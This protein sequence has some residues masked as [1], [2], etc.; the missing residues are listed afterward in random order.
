M[1]TTASGIPQQPFVKHEENNSVENKEVLVVINAFHSELSEHLN[2]PSDDLNIQ[3]KKINALK[4]NAENFCKNHKDQGH[5]VDLDVLL[6]T[7]EIALQKCRAQLGNALLKL[8]SDL[9]ETWARCKKI[10]R[11]GRSDFREIETGVDEL[12]EE[13]LK[14]KRKEK[15][16]YELNLLRVI[17]ER[18]IGSTEPYPFGPPIK[19]SLEQ[20]RAKLEKELNELG[21]STSFQGDLNAKAQNKSGENAEWGKHIR[22]KNKNVRHIKKMQIIRFG[23]E[24]V[25][26]IDKSK[27]IGSGGNGAV[28]NAYPVQ[29]DG[30]IDLHVPL[31]FKFSTEEVEASIEHAKRD[32]YTV[33]EVR[34][35][36]QQFETR[37]ARILTYD[38]AKKPVYQTV[39][40]MPKVPGKSLL[41]LIKT[42]KIQKLSR[43]EKIRLAINIIDTY[44]QSHKDGIFS[45]DTKLE[46]IMVNPET[47]EVTQIDRDN[48]SFTDNSRSP[49]DVCKIFAPTAA[50]D[51]YSLGIDVLPP[52][53]S[54]GRYSYFKGEFSA[55]GG[56]REKEPN[57]RM[58]LAE[59]KII[60]VDRLKDNKPNPN[61][62]NEE[63]TNKVA[64]QKSLAAL[65]SVL[66]CPGYKMS[67]KPLEHK[68][69]LN[70]YL[71]RRAANQNDYGPYD[72]FRLGIRRSDKLSAAQAI[73]AWLDAGKPQ[74]LVV[75]KEQIKALEQGELGRIVADIEGFNDALDKARSNLQN[76]RCQPS[77]PVVAS[78]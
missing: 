62:D 75:T 71:I 23:D 48:F 47:L 40:I 70:S 30:T 76:N 46:N 16:L 36:K 69:L 57:Q 24:L 55:L 15:K 26:A 45:R 59:A 32:L 6:G 35:D 49:E 34:N 31:V 77:S 51:A 33:S 74:D 41:D 25:I 64:H 22:K 63:K 3:L 9:E 67:S 18:L 58:T 38:K 29:A 21:Q 1:A 14:S 72:F 50:S 28:Y 17:I 37:A 66:H 8:W 12:F 2:T 42:G 65:R 20:I 44:E 7:I 54:G 56:M 52:I 73:M 60:L 78:A 4:L 5:N 39:I 43:K 10:G 11:V 27:P 13:I 61:R 19:E 53:L 68:A